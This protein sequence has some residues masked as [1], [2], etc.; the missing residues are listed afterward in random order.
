MAKKEIELIE[1][2]DEFK[3]KLSELIKINS[4]LKEVKKQF[5]DLKDAVVEFMNT[6]KIDSYKVNEGEIKISTTRIGYFNEEKLIPWLQENYPGA[7]ENR[8]TILYDAL[9]DMAYDD[10]NLAKSLIEFK[11]TKEGTRVT[12]R[13]N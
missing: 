4:E 5:S 9:N 11:E 10:K 3:Q 2:V 12:I 8:P 6:Q 13:E 7:V 1:N